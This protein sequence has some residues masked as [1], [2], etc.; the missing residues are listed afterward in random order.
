[1]GVLCIAIYYAFCLDV[2]Q[3]RMNKAPNE[4]RTHSWKN[5]KQNKKEI[6]SLSLSLSLSLALSLFLSPPFSLSLSHKQ[7]IIYNQNVTVVKDMIDHH[8]KSRPGNTMRI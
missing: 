2:A 5:K 7:N 6:N 1:M 4:N 8:K 3:G